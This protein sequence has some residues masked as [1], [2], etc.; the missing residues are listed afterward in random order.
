[1]KSRTKSYGLLGVIL[2]SGLAFL[3]WP[4]NR[5]DALTSSGE[6]LAP[7]AV[8]SEPLAIL[9]GPEASPKG[10]SSLSFLGRDVEL[11]QERVSEGMEP[12]IEL[13]EQVYAVPGLG[14]PVRVE[15]EVTRDP[16]SG[17]IQVVSSVE[18]AADRLIGR[19]EAGVELSEL[20]QRL[21]L[22]GMRLGRRLMGEN[23]FEVLLPSGDLDSVPNGIE[24]AQMSDVAADLVYLEP[25]YIVHTMVD[26]SD[27]SYADGSLWGLDNG[28]QQGGL[29]DV[30]IDAPE[31]WSVRTGAGGIVVAVIDSGINYLHNDLVSNVWVNSLE[32]AG[33]GIDDDGNG[34]V[35]DIHGIN[36]VSGSGDPFD[37]NG[38]GTHCAGTIGA[39]GNNGKGVVG[40]AWDVQLMGLKFLSADGA[41]KTSDAIACIEYALEMGAD[42]MSNSWG[43]GG[44]SQAL[45]D[46]IAVAEESGVAFVAAAGN[47]A[48]DNDESPSYPASYE[49]GNV[50][51][52]ASIDRHGELSEFSNYGVSS[53]DIAAP[54]TDILSTW[55]G[56]ADAYETIS[57]TSMATPHVSGVLALLL[58]EYPESG[59]EEQLRRLYYGGKLLPSLEDE[60]AFGV[61]ASLEGALSL[62]EAPRPPVFTTR[63]PRV[64]QQPKGSDWE[65]SVAVLS[66]YPVSYEWFLDGNKLAGEESILSLAN[67]QADDE[68]VYSVVVSNQDGEARARVR[69]QVLE[70]DAGLADAVDAPVLDFYSYGDAEWQRYAFDSVS[71]SDCIRSG[72][73]GDDAKSSVYVEVMGPARVSFSWRLSSER[74]WDYGSFLLDGEV[75]ASLRAS[76]EWSLHS[77]SL[78]ESRRYRLEWEYLKDGSV[79]AGQDALFVDEIEIESLEEGPPLILQSPVGGVIGTGANYDLSV[80]AIGGELG[81]QWF[82]DGAALAGGTSERLALSAVSTE[83]AGSYG[84]V[85]SNAFG[86]ATSIEARI[87]IADIPV[88][89]SSQPQSM[90]VSVGESVAFEVE[91]EGSLPYTINWYKDGELVLGAESAQFTIPAVNVSDAGDYMVRVSNAFA[92]EGVQSDVASLEVRELSLAPGF[93]KQPQSGYWQIGD[94]VRLSAAV[95][96]SFPF[97]YQWF[98]DGV[99]I[100]GENDRMLLREAV[101]AEDDGSY[102]LEARNA[103]GVASSAEARVRVIGDIGEAIDLPELEWVVEGAG[104]FFAQEEVSFDGV[105]ALESGPSRS[106]FGTSV[107]VSAEVEGPMN[108]FA[109]W[110]EQSSWIP[111]TLGLFVD[112]EMAANLSSGA[113]WREVSAWVPE[114]RHL[115]SFAGLLE[116]ESTVWI[117][118]ARLSAA[119]VLYAESG[120]LA[121][122]GDMDSEL[123]VEAKGAGVLSYQWYR[124]GV[125]IQDAIESVL[126]ISGLDPL[127]EGS[128]FVD[129]ISDFGSV[130]SSTMLV[131]VFDSLAAELG[132]GSVSLEFGDGLSWI[133]T[134]LAGGDVALRSGDG[135]EGAAKILSTVIS[136]PG[137]LVFDLGIRSS[138]WR[139]SLGLF[140]D[141]T[142][143]NYYSDSVEP[144]EEVSLKQ[145]AIF[146]GEGEHQVEWRFNGGGSGAGNTG[147]AYLDNVRLLKEPVFAR[148]PQNARVVEGS[149]TTLSVS[150][151]GPGPYTYQWFKDGVALEG[152]QSSQLALSGASEATAG[153]YYCVAEN[154]AGFST[155]SASAEVTVILGFYEA[156]GLNF[157][158]L[159]FGGT[160]WSPTQ[161]ETPVG[162]GALTL[163][164]DGSNSLGA[165]VFDI[166]VPL[167]EFRALEFW[168][169][170]RSLGPDSLL[171]V[172]ENSNRC[173]DILESEGWQRVVI[174]LGKSGLNRL[175]LNMSKVTGWTDG[176][177][178]ISLAGFRLM[179]E[180]VI[181]QQA[182]AGGVYWGDAHLF[183]T[184]VAGRPPFEYQWFREGLPLEERAEVSGN[185]IRYVVPRLNDASTGE[186]GLSVENGFG[187]ALSDSRE[188][189]LLEADF[190]AAAGLSGTKVRTFGDRLWEVDSE[191]AI[192]GEVSLSVGDLGPLKSSELAFDLQGPGVFSMNWKM[193]SPSGKDEL[194]LTG[195]GKLLRGVYSTSDWLPYEL[196]VPSGSFQFRIQMLNKMASGTKGGRAWLDGMRFRRLDGESFSDWADRVFSG[197]GL[198]EEEIGPLGDPEGD[199]LPNLAEYA[200]GFDPLAPE[201]FP[202]PSLEGGLVV[203]DFPIKQGAVDAE[204][205][206]E[207]SR[208]LETWYPLRSQYEETE[209][210]GKH[211]GRLL[212]FLT[213]EELK[214]G[215]FIRLAIYY[216]EGDE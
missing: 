8:Y 140:V 11:I 41:G 144:F 10:A 76:G 129:T 39:E 137:T 68:G 185:R 60:V 205:G 155:T 169:R 75:D 61:V 199:G 71:G 88:R 183:L 164:P 46:A 150:M 121:L 139:S 43:G 163:V 50:V 27:P 59:L 103:F 213:P 73:I 63:P 45:Y 64:V 119:P 54:G 102:Y 161:I 89:I 80:E 97:T 200:F 65:I 142:Q 160:N 186:Y 132:D 190:G 215:L 3:F 77:V 189:R 79:T 194:S 176:E 13:S 26:P 17:E 58:A 214:E 212:Q 174:P 9:G 203:A 126:P 20:R 128:Y 56:G 36:V 168:I 108:F 35:D 149:D 21:A 67:L 5:S 101:T 122:Q 165:L 116:A 114:G 40:V 33:N 29:A 193:D 177:L 4:R 158:S 113:D 145:R 159:V 1:M 38:H 206:L 49:L 14:Y 178:E 84:V 92:A 24:S 138:G 12:G 90:T 216:A 111:S 30:D 32:I 112:G 162:Q 210:V 74:Y 69:L 7:V 173:V 66:E 99:S 18:M 124:D 62:T 141:G 134:V 202:V 100:P 192:S 153:S 25:D 170:A 191:E 53:V 187:S 136:G 95:E 133:G 55:I 72:E 86:E 37:D 120:S 106:F 2:V 91:L 47:A 123:R 156:L 181:S 148:D 110:R 188:L 151:V 207:L 180:P 196:F 195:S 166:D 182:R 78:P 146:L 6:S 211:Y 31:G 109:Y 22:L 42:L 197:S 16:G 143:I 34:W 147:V 198:G 127:A 70:A 125:P 179:D 93:V 135:G 48:S 23:I 51:A 19:F 57:G 104:Y 117:D 154:E 96:G 52:V 208:D 184:D 87:E 28:G 107:S 131:R 152:Q 204:F 209:E 172:F 130:R 82:K 118:Q 171:E 98:K 85:V 44:Y 157:G 15:R 167:G 201:T 175:T 81:Y 115:L 105:D 94:T 83:D